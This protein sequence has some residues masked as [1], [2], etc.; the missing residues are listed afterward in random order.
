MGKEQS[1]LMKNGY[2]IMEEKENYVV[3]TKE[4]EKFLIK[5]VSQEFLYWLLCI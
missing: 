3:A 5:K 2:T 4:D 1:T